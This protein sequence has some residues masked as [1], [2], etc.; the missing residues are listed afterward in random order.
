MYTRHGG[1]VRK[2]RQEDH[3][4]FEANMGYKVSS[5]HA[6]TAQRNH[7]KQIINQ[8]I[9]QPIN[10][11]KLKVNHLVS[12]LS[13]WFIFSLVTVRKAFC[14]FSLA[15]LNLT[16]TIFSGVLPRSTWYNY[17]EE[18]ISVTIRFNNCFPPWT[19]SDYILFINIFQWLMK[20][21]WHQ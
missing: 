11:L 13:N 17:N 5:R 6:W 10:W 12:N 8:S 16:L 21:D 20:F 14:N 18:S 19:E 1:I 4:E 7:L 9:S 2:L 3:Y 15:R